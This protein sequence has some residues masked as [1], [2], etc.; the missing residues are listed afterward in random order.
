MRRSA[1]SDSPM[2]QLGAPSIDSMNAPAK[3]SIAKPPASSSG[4][5]VPT[6]ALSSASVTSAARRTVAVSTAPTAPCVAPPRWS[7]NQCPE[8]STPDRP[9]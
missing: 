4:S 6:Y 1:G 7:I 8:C 5:P 3:P 2:T 9:R